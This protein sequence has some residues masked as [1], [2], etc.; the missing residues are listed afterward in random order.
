MPI[1]D[2]SFDEVLTTTRAVR[3]RLDLTRPVEPEVIQ[4]CIELALHAPTGGNRQGWHFLVVTDAAKKTEIARHYG[5]AWYAY[6]AQRRTAEGGAVDPQTERVRDSAQYL[7]DHMHEVPVL[8]IPLAW[9]SGPQRL[10]YGA[11]ALVGTIAVV[12]PWTIRNYIVFH[13]FVP[14]ANTT[15]QA[16]ILVSGF[17]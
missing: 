6:N 1:L 12:A 4:R 15:G 14:V 17:S 5:K 10:V 2:L 16:E 7:A 11:L 9:R 8:V 13:R 3:K